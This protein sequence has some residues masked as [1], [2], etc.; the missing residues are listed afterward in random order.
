MTG[1]VASTGGDKTIRVNINTLVK[2]PRYGKYVRKR[3]GLAV[4][5]PDNQAAPGDLV[6]V[7]PCRPISKTKSWRLVRVVR[8]RRGGGEITE[9]AAGD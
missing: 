3:T 8:P 9:T 2:H 5:D 6:E 1:V 4:H 7:L